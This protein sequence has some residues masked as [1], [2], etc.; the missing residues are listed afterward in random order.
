[1]WNKK[2]W[3]FNRKYLSVKRIFFAM[4]KTDTYNVSV[5]QKIHLS[6]ASACHVGNIPLQQIFNDMQ[7][8][9]KA[10]LTFSSTKFGFAYFKM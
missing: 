10:I 4:N 1:M 7:N 6:L 2:E 8:T 9:E 5:Y 3:R